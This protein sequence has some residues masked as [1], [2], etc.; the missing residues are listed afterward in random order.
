MHSGKRFLKIIVISFLVTFENATI[1]VDDTKCPI[2]RAERLILDNHCASLFDG[3]VNG[4]GPKDQVDF[5][6]DAAGGGG[7]HVSIARHPIRKQEQ[8]TLHL[9]S[10]AC[11][12]IINF[13]LVLFLCASTSLLLL[14]E[15]L[16]VVIEQVVRHGWPRDHKTLPIENHVP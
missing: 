1:F 14:S 12:D 3:G 5:L 6:I 4:Q 8:D 10:R 7:T 15:K 11:N 9:T 2:S 13:D 16:L